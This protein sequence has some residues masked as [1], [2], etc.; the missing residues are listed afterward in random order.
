MLKLNLI[1]YEI[2]RILKSN[3]LKFSFSKKRKYNY[4]KFRC[5]NDNYFDIDIKKIL[6]ERKNQPIQISRYW[7]T[8]KKR[9]IHNF[10][11]SKRNCCDATLQ[12]SRPITYLKRAVHECLVQI[13]N[14]AFP[15][16]V[17]GPVGTEQEPLW[18]LEK[19]QAGGAT[20]RW[21]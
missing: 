10:R 21:R 4:L 11:F 17:G 6:I 8:K 13:N 9:F 14:E 7:Q 20:R 2:F 12:M 19:R 16:R 18:A 3:F 1:K 15:V 5:E